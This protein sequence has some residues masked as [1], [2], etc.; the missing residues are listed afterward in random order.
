MR[1]KMEDVRWGLKWG[2]GFSVFMTLYAVGLYLVLGSEPFDRVG[3]RPQVVLAVYVVGSLTAGLVVG[4]LRRHT[5]TRDGSMLVGTV[6]ALPVSFAMS[7]AFFGKPSAWSTGDWMQCVFMA[8][9]FG[10]GLGFMWHGRNWG[11]G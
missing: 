2:T 11:G 8:V 5:S 1:A 10:A 6:A 4:L 9:L 7:L 3:L